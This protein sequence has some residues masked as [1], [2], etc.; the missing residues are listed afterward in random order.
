MKHW[1]INSLFC[2]PSKHPYFF[3]QIMS[4]VL[5]YQACPE[6]DKLKQVLLPLAERKISM[7]KEQ[8]K[9]KQEQETHLYLMVLEMQHKF[10]EALAVLDE[11]LGQKLEKETT[12]VDF[13]ETKRLEYM[14]KLEMWAKVN[15]LAKKMLKKR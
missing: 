2:R 10:K 5:Q 9:M 6:D 1:K 15:A 14:K 3:W 7:Y 4:I 12:F 13:V 8:G 11:P